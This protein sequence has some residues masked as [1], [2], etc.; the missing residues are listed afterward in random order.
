LPDGR[1]KEVCLHNFIKDKCMTNAGDKVVVHINNNFLDDR[2]ENLRLIE[3]SDYFPSRNNRKR[4]ITLPPDIGFLVEDIPKYV[5]F[6]KASGEHGDR[7]AIEIPQLHLFMKL[8]SSKKISLKDKFEEVKQ[9]LN[10]IYVSY[11]EVNPCADDALKSALNASFEYIINYS[12][13]LYE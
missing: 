9:R 4:T 11:P 10:E 6:M 1:I 13:A 3:L 5:S 8:S 2:V 7:F 12:C